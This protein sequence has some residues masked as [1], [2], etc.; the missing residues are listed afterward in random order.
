M[1]CCMPK[2][3]ELLYCIWNL[4]KP[5]RKMV[6]INVTK[7]LANLLNAELMIIHNGGHLNKKAGYKKFPLLMESIIK[8]NN[9]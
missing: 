6:P 3:N 4:W 9:P 8:I 5:R 7:E 2:Q 1:H